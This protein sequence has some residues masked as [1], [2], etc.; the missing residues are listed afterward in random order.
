M[1]LRYKKLV[2]NGSSFLLVLLFVYTGTS[3][4]LG[5][6]LFREQLSHVNFLKP[7]A[8]LLAF[9]LPILEIVTGLAIA[10]KPTMRLGLWSAAILMTS[11]TIYVAIMLAGDQTKLPCSC[12]GVIK[13]MSWKQHLY[14][15]ILFMLLAWYSIKITGIRQRE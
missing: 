1:L 10:Y 4:L 11:F 15:N 8:P 3:K 6:L 14:F 13:V 2:L 12:G 7:I 9:A 5:I